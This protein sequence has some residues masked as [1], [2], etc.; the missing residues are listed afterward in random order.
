M[1]PRRTRATVEEFRT[2]RRKAKMKCRER[3]TA[4]KQPNFA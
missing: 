1:L 4:Y 2:K 3:K